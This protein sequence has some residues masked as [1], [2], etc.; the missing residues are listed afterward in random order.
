MLRDVAQE[1][2]LPGKGCLDCLNETGVVAWPLQF[3]DYMPRGACAVAARSKDP[4]FKRCDHAGCYSARCTGHMLSSRTARDPFEKKVS[5][6]FRRHAKDDG[7][8]LPQLLMRWG[9]TVKAKAAELR[10]EYE[11]GRCPK[12]K[13]GC[14]RRWT[15]LPNG[16][17]DMTFDR[18]DPDADFLPHNVGLLCITCQLAKL[19]M[20][21]AQFAI[22]H[23]CWQVYDELPK[24]PKFTDRM[25]IALGMKRKPRHAKQPEQ[26]GSLLD[27]WVA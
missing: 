22:R 27:D 24:A 17:R 4:N 12:D 25:L 3:F 1:M 18:I 2:G 20:P 6:S 19:N 7:I 8:S 15:V 14:G 5:D 11:T 16:P 26:T 10:Q 21:P 13:L 23:R 9:T